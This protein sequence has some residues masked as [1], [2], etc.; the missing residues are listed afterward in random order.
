MFP[1]NFSALPCPQTLK[2]FNLHISNKSCSSPSNVFLRALS[3]TGKFSISYGHS[4]KAIC[5]RSAQNRAEFPGQLGLW[6]ALWG[7][8]GRSLA[9]GFHWAC[10]IHMGLLLYSHACCKCRSRHEVLG[11]L[12]EGGCTHSR[13][14]MLMHRPYLKG[15]LPILSYVSVSL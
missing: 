10:L 6:P 9:A 8:Q 12:E 4:H 15:L 13:F 2:T 3:V 11:K 1:F 7:F 14:L 5:S